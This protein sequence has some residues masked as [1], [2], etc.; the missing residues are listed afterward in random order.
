[1][2]NLKNC[3]FR[4]LKVQSLHLGNNI[5]VIQKITVDNTI[6]V[7]NSQITPIVIC[8]TK[9]FTESL[10]YLNYFLDN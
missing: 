8:K 7:L 10:M 9:L 2:N 6:P 1:M 4:I 3:T 5:G